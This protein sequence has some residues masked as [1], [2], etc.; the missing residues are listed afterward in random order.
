M[1][2]AVNSPAAAAFLSA[3]RRRLAP[4]TRVAAETGNKDILTA[5]DPPG[6]ADL[7]VSPNGKYLVVS[8]PSLPAS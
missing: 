4:C 8:Q 2:A 1:A 5:I 7:D 3:A 6:A